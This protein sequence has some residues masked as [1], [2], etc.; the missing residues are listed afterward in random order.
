MSQR[1]MYVRVSVE[2]GLAFMIKSMLE[3]M[4]TEKKSEITLEDVNE[5][6]SENTPKH[7]LER[8][9]K[10]KC[11]L[12]DFLQFFLKMVIEEKNVFIEGKCW[13]VLRKSWHFGCCSFGLV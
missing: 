12:L 9:N 13:E 1:F 11:K 3:W 8:L 5:L 4:E 6:C 2:L 10:K 7:V